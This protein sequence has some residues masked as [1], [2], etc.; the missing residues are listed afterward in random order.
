MITIDGWLASSDFE[1]LQRVRSSVTGEIAL[2]LAGLHSCTSAGI[3][4]LQE[5]LDAGATLAD[6]TPFL[7]IVLSKKN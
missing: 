1:E 7:R 4:L 5:W 3:S 6:A 2:K